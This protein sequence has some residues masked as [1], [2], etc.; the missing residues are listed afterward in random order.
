MFRNI[1]LIV[2]GII[3]GMGLFYLLSPGD[4]HESHDMADNQQQ[5]YTC[6]MHPEVLLNE[7][8]NCPICGM[9]LIPVK[10]DAPGSGAEKKILYWQAPMDAT[11]IYDKPGK[12]KMGMDLVAVYQEDAGLGSGLIKI[13]GR[14][15]Q[16]MNLRT[17]EVSNRKIKRSIRAYGRVTVAEDYQY[18]VTT[19]IKGWIEK[20]YFNTTG[21]YVK[22]GQA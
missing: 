3:I 15:R 10:N 12:S 16:N 5:L 7:P 1:I 17:T 9:N 13:D 21:Q 14:V 6:G 20:L 18:T 2:V 11:E 19:K 8:G 4:S 22:K